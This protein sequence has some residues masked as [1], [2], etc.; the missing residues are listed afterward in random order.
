MNG[1][2]TWASCVPAASVRIGRGKDAAAR[3]V[4]PAGTLLDLAG[5][6]PVE[7]AL[8]VEMGLARGDRVFARALRPP[9][10][11]A[12][13]DGS[14]VAVAGEAAHPRDG[15]IDPRGPRRLLLILGRKGPQMVGRGL[16]RGLLRELAELACEPLERLDVIVIQANL[17]RP[18][19]DPDLSGDLISINTATAATVGGIRPE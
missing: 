17:R 3:R 6:G 2:R 12:G 11:G 4:R 13:E 10:P 16:V 19:S 8:P 15:G 18:R 14:L 7:T 1:S 5:H 9:A